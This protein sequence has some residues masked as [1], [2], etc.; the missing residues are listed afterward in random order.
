MDNNEITRLY[1]E[2]LSEWDD[3]RLR[4]EQLQKVEW[5]TFD[6]GTFKIKAQFNPARAVSSNAKLDKAS[7]AKRKCFLCSENR[8]DI[9]KGIKMNDRFTLLINPFPIL[10]EH[11]TLPLNQHKEQEIK[12]YI[13]DFLDFAQMMTSHTLL[14]NGPQCGAS[15]PDHI[16]FQA[17]KRGQIPFEEDYKTVARKRI[18]GDDESHADELLEFGR[19]C[20]LVESASKEKMETMFHL[21]YNQYQIGEEEPKWNL[22]V[23]FEEGIWHLFLFLRK[24]H[25]PT[26][27]FAEGD[28]YMM[29]SPGAIDIAGVFV[30]PRKEDFD[31]IN[32]EIIKDVLQQVS[33]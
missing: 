14:Y 29:I 9:Q 33:L 11:F 21:L 8:P 23:L 19:K 7:I 10:L 5:K 2:Q 4:V 13:R 31:R 32:K 20:I 30:L 26:Q 28:D 17:V 3:F 22:F 25:R 1:E 16:H 12:P 24:T 27:F 15:A 6:F 18:L